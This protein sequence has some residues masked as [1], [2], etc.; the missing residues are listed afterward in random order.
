ME[1]I[2]RKRSA[3][4]PIVSTAD[5]RHIR[6]NFLVGV[7]LLLTASGVN[8]CWSAEPGWTPAVIKV[9]ADRAASQSTPI[10][11]RPYRPLHVYGNT[12]RRAYYRDRVAPSAD[13]LRATSQMLRSSPAGRDS[14]GR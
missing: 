10:L 3:G 14:R 8:R 1:R 13:D 12:V 6:H 11:E 5:T 4:S 7:M 2:L 9:G